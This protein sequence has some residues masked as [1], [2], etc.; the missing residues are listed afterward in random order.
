ME[1]ERLVVGCMCG[2]SIDGL[3][4]ALLRIDGRGIGMQA[5][6]VRWME[7]PFGELAAGLRLAAVQE[8][9]PAANL[10]SLGRELA[11][12][13]VTLIEELLDGGRC[14]LIAVHGQTVFHRPPLTWQLIDLPHIAYALDISV[15]GDLRA[16][17]LSAGGQGAPI[18]PLAD[19]VLLRET[20]ER[21]AVVNLG[22]FSNLTRLPANGQVEHVS[23]GDLCACNHVLDG[24]ARRCL[25]ADYDD[26]GAAAGAGREHAEARADLEARLR[27]QAGERR[28]LGTHDELLDWIDH[29]SQSI[30]GRDLARSACAAIAAVIGEACAD[31][32]R[33]IIAGGG[34]RNQTLLAAIRR[35]CPVPVDTSDQ[36]RVPV[37][38]REAAA[39]AVLGALSQDQVSISVPAVTCAAQQRVA[40]TWVHPA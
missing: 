8:P 35:A 39:W 28:S 4:V 24:I 16:A 15:V 29:W 18:T 21:R 22:G 38:K 10:A 25:D 17:D 23:G 6:V 32:E 27:T 13:H 37:G 33:V 3:D 11:E 40:G 30:G 2:T 5:E 14:D 36:H 1:G 7:R 19:F 20:G 9:L 34:C 31:V 26:D 12:L